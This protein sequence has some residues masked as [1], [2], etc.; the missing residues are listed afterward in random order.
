[1]TKDEVQELLDEQWGKGYEVKVREV[2]IKPA[3]QSTVV[4]YKVTCK[5]DGMC[6]WRVKCWGAASQGSEIVTRR[7][8]G[9]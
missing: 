2:I 5:R 4:F 1:M 9:S 7:K 6:E 8:W 3:W